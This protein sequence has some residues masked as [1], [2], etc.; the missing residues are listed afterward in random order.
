MERKPQKCKQCG[1]EIYF[2]G[3]CA[4][5][6]AENEKIEILTL[7]EDEITVKIGQICDE[8]EKIG[9]LDKERH[10]FI[11]LVDY[12]DINTKEIAETAF[13]KD[14][15]YP[16]ELYKDASDEIVKSMIE[17]IKKDDIDAGIAGHLLLCLAAA[18]GDEVFQTF[19]ELEH[20]PREWRKKLYVNPSFYASYGGWSY[21][22]D[23]NFVEINFDKCY[24]MVK[25]TLEEKRNS[26]VK[27]GVKTDEKCI[28]CGC[29]IVNLME[30]DGRDARLEF[31]GIDGIVKAKCCPNCFE[32]S[33]G[34]FCRY[35]ING[36]S[37]IIFGKDS[38]R[39]EDYL[40]ESGV[41]ELS[42]NTYVLGNKPVP[43]RYAADWNGG[44]SVGGFAFWIQ[45]CEIKMCPDCGKPMKY[46]AQ[47]QWDTVID[48]MEGNAYIEI[49]KGC[50]IMVMLH[51]QT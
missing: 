33:D 43:L 39:S 23:G 6:R 22:K 3:I 20:N 17:L 25:G 18:G 32:F 15:F 31:L 9:D 36:E 42:S 47:I 44:S 30:I 51:Q 4:D 24:P 13:K 27:I 38:F 50:K 26:P 11:K 40:C 8:L 16:C 37:E 34:D 41:E 35:T 21:D 10:I 49:C 14:V 5:C 45:D 46:I 28:K 2:E 29:T 48:G 1:R 19:L 7:T 12:R